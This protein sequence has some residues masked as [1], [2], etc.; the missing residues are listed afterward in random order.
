MKINNKSY[1]YRSCMF[2]FRVKKGKMITYQKYKQILS[3][4]SKENC[5]KHQSTGHLSQF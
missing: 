1:K 4:F 5:C 2:Q 3:F